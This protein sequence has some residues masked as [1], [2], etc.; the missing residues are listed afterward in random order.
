[1]R[2]KKREMLKTT[3]VSTLKT[4][5]RSAILWA[6][7]IIVLIMTVR[8]ALSVHYMQVLLDDDYNIIGEVTDYDPRY[9]MTYTKYLQVMRN[10]A[11]DILLSPLFAVI[12]TMLVLTREHKDSFFEVERAGGT[13]IKSYFFGR[14]GA[15]VTVNVI[16]GLVSLFTA[17]FVYSA[18][19]HVISRCA[20]TLLEYLWVTV[21]RLLLLFFTS[22]FH[23][24]LFYIALTYAVGQLMKSGFAGAVAGS[25]Y[26]LFLRMCMYNV[27]FRMSYVYSLLSPA[28]DD[29]YLFWGYIGVDGYLDNIFGYRAWGTLEVLLRTGLVYVVVALLFAVAYF[30]I[31]KRRI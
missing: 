30:G 3:Y 20:F 21:S 10:S 16:M 23:G 22:S 26:I 24:M 31:K 8:D 4:L 1:M 2:R 28:P 15:I 14:L 5:L 9:E 12:T 7:V 6:A 27:H 18:T 17:V 11:I 25:G 29:I 19:R 13:S